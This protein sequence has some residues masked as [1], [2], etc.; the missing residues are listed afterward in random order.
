MLVIFFFSSSEKINANNARQTSSV[1]RPPNVYMNCNKD[2]VMVTHATIS[3]KKTVTMHSSRYK[4]INRF[5]I[6]QVILITDRHTLG[7]VNNFIG[8]GNDSKRMNMTMVMHTT[9]ISWKKNM[10]VA[11]QT[12]T[13]M[14]KKI[15]IDMTIVMHGPERPI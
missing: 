11:I 3:Q 5:L 14:K 4:S 7:N 6:F 12:T 9:M 10:I 2:H 13:I 15:Y 8:R 1:N